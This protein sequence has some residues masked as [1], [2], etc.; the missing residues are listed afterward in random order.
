MGRPRSF[1]TENAIQH[2]MLLFWER[3]YEAT[4]MADLSAAMGLN[5]PS[6]YA[7]FKNKEMLFQKCVEAYV[8]SIASY[9]PRAFEEEPTVELA[10]QRFISEAIEAFTIHDQPKGCLLISGAT[11]CSKGSQGAQDFLTTYRQGSEAVI[12]DRI[13]RGIQEGDM[14]LETN[15][16]LL[17]KYISVTVQ[18]MAAQARDGVDAATLQEV[19]KIT[20]AQFNL[21]K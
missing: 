17:A 11:N 15:A 14:P 8:E 9:A 10:M 1:D 5:P 19:A 3:G 6:I 20:L 12:A 13:Q 16:A 4:S 2:A 18:G 21:S 7:A